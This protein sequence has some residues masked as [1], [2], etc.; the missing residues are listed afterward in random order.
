MTAN[1][2]T[3]HAAGAAS[4]E[5]PLAGSLRRAMIDNAPRKTPLPLHI[6]QSTSARSNGFDQLAK[7]ARLIEQDETLAAIVRGGQAER[8]G[9]S[10]L[11]QETPPSSH[12]VRED[13]TFEHN[14][15]GATGSA[16]V[17]PGLCDGPTGEPLDPPEYGEY[18]GPDYSNGLPDQG[19]ALRAFAVLIGLAL[20][21]SAGAFA[22]WALSNGRGH[23]DEARVMAASVSPD[24]TAPSPQE[25]SRLDEPLRDQSDERSAD[26]TGRTM[27]GAEEPA[28]ATP[29]MPQAVPPMSIAVGPVPTKMAELT[30]G[31]T[32]PGSPADAAQSQPPDVKKPAPRRTAPGAT[33]PSGA[34][35]MHYVVQLSS[36]RGEAAAHARSQV[37]QNKYRDAFAGRKPFIRRADLGDRGVY[38]RVQMG[39]FAIGEANEICGNLKKSGADC[40]VQRN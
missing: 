20:G 7:L 28:D 5:D 36:E 27:T 21:G 19:R 3:A 10:S 11:P 25:Q 30:P 31:P 34:H 33:E 9:E 17:D 15:E 32:P 1:D 6:A 2:E 8:R 18:D 40:V 29:P 24:K 23:S 14:W 39:P 38:Y 4:P 16:S 37:L 26:A 22:Y 13:K 35:G 12:F